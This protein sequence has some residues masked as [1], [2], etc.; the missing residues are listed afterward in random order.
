MKYLSLF[1]LN[2]LKIIIYENIWDCIINRY[3]NDIVLCTDAVSGDYK[4]T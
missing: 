1:A 3:L 2:L 4:F